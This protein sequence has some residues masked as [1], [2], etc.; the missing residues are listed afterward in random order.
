MSQFFE[1]SW[2]IINEAEIILFK[3]YQTKIDLMKM[4][5]PMLVAVFEY[6][7]WEKIRNKLDKRFPQIPD[8]SKV[9]QAVSTS[10]YWFEITL[11]MFIVRWI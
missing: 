2:Q 11:C 8:L 6:P 4:K 10:H 9:Q 7:G 3:L 1:R 5:D